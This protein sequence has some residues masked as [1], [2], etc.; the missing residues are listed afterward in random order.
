MHI[1]GYDDIYV[2]VNQLVSYNSMNIRDRNEV[3]QVASSRV[4]HCIYQELTT[5][6]E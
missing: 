2:I 4:I 3:L 5:V 6:Y 1:N